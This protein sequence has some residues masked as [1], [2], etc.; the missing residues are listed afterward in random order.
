MTVASNHNRNRH[1]ALAFGRA[2]ET[3]GAWA[4]RLKGYRIIT[5]QFRR[6][7][8]EID[9]IARRGNVLVFVEVKA[10]QSAATAA[11]AI[12]PHQQERIAR[13]A[14]AFVQERPD[15]ASLDIRFDA[16]LITQGP[17][18]GRWPLHIVDAWRPGD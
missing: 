7:V 8:G 16:L 10:R 3:V 5:R 11:A 1:A 15:L 12:S 6:P 17:W 2:G 13:T 18:Y 9:I 14:A 4:L